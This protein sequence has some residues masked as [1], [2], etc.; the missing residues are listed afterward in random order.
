MADDDATVAAK[1]RIRDQVAEIL[2]ED[3][4]AFWDQLGFNVRVESGIERLRNTLNG[5]AALGIN[6]GDPK[7]MAKLERALAWLLAGHEA[8]LT[9]NKR[10]MTWVTWLVGV[11][12]GLL[13]LLKYYLEWR[14]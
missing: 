11:L 9:R 5:F 4:P 8:S 6:V 12:V 7:E 13:T 1:A 3:R 14:H 2:R 10:L